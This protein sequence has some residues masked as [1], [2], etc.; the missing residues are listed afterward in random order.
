TYFVLSYSQFDLMRSPTLGIVL[1]MIPFHQEEV[2][3]LVLMTIPHQVAES[4]A[5]DSATR[6]NSLESSSSIMDPSPSVL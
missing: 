3:V 1:T 6:R 2:L 5:A 4:M